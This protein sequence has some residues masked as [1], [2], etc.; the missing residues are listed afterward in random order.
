LS[1][2]NYFTGW[3]DGQPLDPEAPGYAKVMLDQLAW[4]AAALRTARATTTYPV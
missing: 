4:W 3:T 1:F 2:P